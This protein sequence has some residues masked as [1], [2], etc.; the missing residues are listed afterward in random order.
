[1]DAVS[2]ILRALELNANYKSTVPYC[3]PQLGRRGMYPDSV[4]PE[5]AREKTHRLMHFLAYADGA[6]SL[7]EV[8][9][10]RNES[11]FLY[12]DIVDQC[13]RAGLIEG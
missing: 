2:K 11:I 9:E 8:A 1:V 3:E 10:L 13:I 12:Q 4:N 6:S 5:D 7:R